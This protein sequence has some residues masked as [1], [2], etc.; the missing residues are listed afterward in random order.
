VG[1]AAPNIT[2]VD[3]SPVGSVHVHA[4]ERVFNWF[5]FYWILSFKY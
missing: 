2:L 3:W 4:R 1:A 5:R